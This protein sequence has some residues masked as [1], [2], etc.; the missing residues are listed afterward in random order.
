MNKGSAPTGAD[1]DADAAEPAAGRF[2]TIGHGT[3]FA[4]A[5]AAVVDYLT[6]AIPMGF[7]A[8]TRYDGYRQLY[9]EVRDTTYGLHPGGSH[10]WSESFCINMATGQ[11]PQI[12]PDAMAIAE[13]ANSGVAKQIGIGAYIGIPIIRANG[14]LFGTLCGLDPETRS[15]DLTKHQPLLDLLGGLLS[16]I[17]QADL[18]RTENER[19]LERAQLAADTD[20][21]TGLLNRRGWD[22][23]MQLEEARFRRFGDPGAVIVIDLDQL[24]LVNDTNGHAAGDRYIKRAADILASTVRT[25]DVVAR[26]GGDEFGVIATDMIPADT[27][28]LVDRI[29]SAL[30][31]A[32][33]SGSVG[34]APYT[35][36]AGFRGAFAKA[37]AAMYQDKQRR[38]SDRMTEPIIGCPAVRRP[39]TRS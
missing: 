17:L 1:A 28:I 25:L 35:I 5:S 10:P 20:Q 12:A 33:V 19:N 14:D 7:W 29:I 36:V 16:T 2:P 38:R 15:A 6:T 21:L 32:G 26:L 24:K 34:H 18:Q 9:L 3:G 22:K 30:E 23:F 13:Y 37:D 39:A 8:V 31:S 4:E 11:T 27:Q